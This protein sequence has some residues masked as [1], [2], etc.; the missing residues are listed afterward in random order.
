MQDRC[1]P[2]IGVN[3][4]ATSDPY[5][6][7]KKLEAFRENG[8]DAVEVSLD[9]FPLIIDGKPCNAWIDYSK[10]MLSEFP[11]SYSAHIGR[12]LNL[13]D[14]GNLE[15]HMEVLTTSIDICSRLSFSPLVLHYELKSRDRKVERDFLQAHR[16][17]AD[18]AAKH[19]I[20]IVVENIEVE[21]VDPVIDFV[22]EVDSP[23]LRLAF[24]TGH[25]FLA[26]RYFHFDFLESF[27]KGLP[28]LVHIH[29]SDNTGNF[30]ELRITDRWAYDSLP[31]GM[32][33]EYG[34][35][36][37]HLPPFFGKVPYNELFD[38]LFSTYPQW[39]GMF[40]CEYYSDMFLPFNR[41]VQEKVRRSI[42]EARERNVQRR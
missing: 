3:L 40:V 29:L 26:S 11:F 39:E 32:R 21:L 16:E 8:F 15:K 36:D 31:M 28:F 9:S 12:G 25:A 7:G 4:P 10:G 14:T 1:D 19:G 24:D 5:A 22:A 37:I 34:R 35:G 42:I 13:R 33:F 2:V 30:E 23:N 41:E 27:R 20:T 6:T 18:Y 17:A 38:M